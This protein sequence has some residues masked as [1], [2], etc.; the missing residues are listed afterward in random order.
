[1]KPAKLALFAFFLTLGLS[2]S[3]CSL[4]CSPYLDDYAAYGSRTPRIDMKHGR[5]G[6]IFSDPQLTGNAVPYSGSPSSNELPVHFDS[7]GNENELISGSEV[8][9]DEGP[10]GDAMD[11]IESKKGNDGF[12]E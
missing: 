3:G 4:C 6:S 2:L 12:D 1:M 11:A 7:E 5:V 10:W 9:V 8:V